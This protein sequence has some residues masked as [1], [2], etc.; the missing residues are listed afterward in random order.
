MIQISKMITG[1]SQPQSTVHLALTRYPVR[2]LLATANRGNRIAHLRIGLKIPEAVVIHDPELALAERLGNGQ[3]Y[4]RFGEHDL[5]P[6]KLNQRSVLLLLGDRFG[7]LL[8]GARLGYPQ[9]RAGLVGLEIGADIGADVNLR[10]VDR[11]DF[12]RG[13][14]VE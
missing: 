12:K 6:I 5:G 2:P 7:P 11:D 3:G 14:R 9:I 10:D 8:F 1:T 4:L 13:L